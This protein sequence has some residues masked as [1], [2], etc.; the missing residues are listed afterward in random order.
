MANWETLFNKAF[1][2]STR[3][4]KRFERTV[5]L[6]LKSSLREVRSEISKFYSENA[7]NGK[8]T[9]SILSKNKRYQ[10]LEK[11]IFASV[12]KSIETAL[13]TFK[14][15]LPV[16]FQEGFN[17]TAFAFDSAYRTRF[18]WEAPTVSSLE[19]MFSTNNL[20]NFYFNE[21]V[22]NF[23]IEAK[24]KLRQAIMH[25]TSIGKSVSAMT[26]DVKKAV[27]TINYNATRII[28]TEG[29]A[30]INAGMNAVY[31]QAQ[32][33]GVNGKFIWSAV[34]D[35]RTRPDH[36]AMQGEEKQPDGFFN[37]PGGERAPYPGWVGLSAG[38]RINC[39][40]VEVYMIEG[41]SNKLSA[42]IESNKVGATS[43]K[44]WMEEHHAND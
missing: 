24:R 23:P 30:A 1:L 14:Q 25:N 32:D 7:V 31:L 22:K 18:V 21:A 42:E 35:M 29:T 5:A 4:Q 16:Q 10:N 26:A 37:G 20:N 9:V 15:S 2:H 39:R 41:V 27:N 40:C 33:L 34:N 17:R 8:I 13:A 38:Q 43:Y 19:R 44:K 36:A 6:A 11:S 12:D 28:Q 3:L